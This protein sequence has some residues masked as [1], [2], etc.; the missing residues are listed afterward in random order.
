MIHLFKKEIHKLS[1]VFFSSTFIFLT[2]IGN[3]ILI[4]ATIIVYEVEKGVNPHIQNYFDSLWWGI[5]TITTVAYGDIIPQTLIGR[6][7]AIVLMYTGT[8]LFVSFT[9]IIVTFLLQ[10]EVE[11][12]VGPM[13]KEMRAEGKEQVHLEK[14]L[15]DIRDRLD[16]LEKK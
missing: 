15:L 16:R 4:A 6:I 13:K 2:V 10:E 5:S 11:K 12:E 3:L 7:I 1:K 14:I 9:G 8:V